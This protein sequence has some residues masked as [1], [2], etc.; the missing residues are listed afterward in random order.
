MCARPYLTVG[1][2]EP[3]PRFVL[4]GPCAP[5]RVQDRVLWKS[6][7]FHSVAHP[8]L[9]KLL[10]FFWRCYLLLLFVLR[11]HK[12]RLMPFIRLISA[13]N[14][15]VNASAACLIENLLKRLVKFFVSEQR[16]V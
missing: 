4:R 14:R 10:Q 13:V 1:L 2:N 12:A 5:W 16:S 9:P 15:L 3:G 8:L 7:L 11:K 6:Y